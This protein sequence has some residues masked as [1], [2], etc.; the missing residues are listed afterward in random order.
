M[1]PCKV[2]MK[3]MIFGVCSI[4]IHQSLVLAT[5]MKIHLILLQSVEVDDHQHSESSLLWSSVKSDL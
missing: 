4:K 3:G 1:C 2:Y 5:W